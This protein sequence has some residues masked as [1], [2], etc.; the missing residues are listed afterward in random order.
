MLEFVI[1]SY[2]LK[3]TLLLDLTKVSGKVSNNFFM[4]F[5]SFSKYTGRK[6]LVD[7]CLTFETSL[8]EKIIIFTMS[9]SSS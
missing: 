4:K 6:I 1:G 2:F 3:C 7:S 5:S 9:F 8:Y